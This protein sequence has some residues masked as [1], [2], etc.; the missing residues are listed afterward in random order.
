MSADEVFWALVLR[1]QVANQIPGILTEIRPNVPLRI[2]VELRF[3][4]ILVQR[5]STQSLTPYSDES[6]YLIA[7]V[8]D[9]PYQSES[10]SKPKFVAYAAGPL[11][12][13]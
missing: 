5:W 1:C 9:G 13:P 10:G 6:G 11:D 4:G 3:E 12:Y 7:N 8:V 2:I